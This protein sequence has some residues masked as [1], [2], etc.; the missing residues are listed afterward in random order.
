L[1]CS[2]GV[3]RRLCA[4]TWSELTVQAQVHDETATSPAFSE[5]EKRFISNIK[6]SS[7]VGM[8]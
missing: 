1:E 8:R 4:G 6:V 7:I 2:A 5:D 3:S